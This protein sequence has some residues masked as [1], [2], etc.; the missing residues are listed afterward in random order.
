[1]SPPV[2][3]VAPERLSSLDGLRGISCLLVLFA[4]CILSSPR[5]YRPFV[6]RGYGA[7]DTGRL[8]WWFTY[9]PLHVLWAGDEVLWVFFILSGLVLVKGLEGAGLS[10]WVAYYPRRLIRLYLPVWGAML[11]TTGILFALS[12]LPRPSEQAEVYPSFS[13]NS[14]LHDLVLVHPQVGLLDRPLWTM[15][16]EVLFSMLLPLFFFFSAVLFRRATLV[17]GGLF[18]A[19]TFVGVERGNL[20]MI[21]LPMFGLGALI[22]VS[23]R[24]HRWVVM[25][26]GHRGRAAISVGVVIV[27]LTVQWP[28]NAITAGSDAVHPIAFARVISLFGAMLVVMLVW[29]WQ[30]ASRQFERRAPQWLGVRAFSIYIIHFP[31]LQALLFVFR[32]NNPLFMLAIGVPAVLA[33]SAVFFRLCEEPS[34]RFAQH[35]GRRVR[36]SL[37]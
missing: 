37:P 16:L 6:E 29:K 30:A 1:M 13:V 28:M 10:S 35:V 21:M 19:T 23:T 5:Y 3:R 14:L 7:H 33:A 11:V 26:M 31:V 18:L 4:H 17:K 2:P 32:N 34:H 12:P 24:W 22:A 8:F 36:A 27:L 20:L 25:W 9:T 15:R